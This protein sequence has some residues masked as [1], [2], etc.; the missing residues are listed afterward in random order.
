[1]IDRIC[2]PVEKLGVDTFMIRFDRVGTTNTRRSNEIW[3]MATQ[4]GDSEY[5]RAVQQAVL[6]FPLQNRSG[7]EQRIT[8]PEIPDQR[9]GTPSVQLHATSDANVP[10][11]YYVREG[12]AEIAGDTINFTALPPCSKFPVSVTVVAW[13]YGRAIEPRLQTAEP[14]ERTFFITAPIVLR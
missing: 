13:Q 4:P 8:F 12:P 10:V 14:V 11:R 3:L 6:H 7:A 2:G 9:A 5:K 1:M